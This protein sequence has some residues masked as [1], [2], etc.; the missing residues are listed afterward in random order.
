[1]LNVKHCYVL[2][3]T[4]TEEA[5]GHWSGPFSFLCNHARYSLAR[6]SPSRTRPHFSWRCGSMGGGG[7]MRFFCAG[8]QP[9]GSIFFISV[10]GTTGSVLLCCAMSIPLGVNKFVALRGL[11]SSQG[12]L[13][14][15]VRLSA[16]H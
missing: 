13:T 12:V 11:S 2:F 8:G 1:M 4:I 7:S 14:L 5:A 6:C 9:G 15:P 10:K 16:G 3:T